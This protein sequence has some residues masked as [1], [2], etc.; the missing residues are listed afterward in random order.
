[1][2][3]KQKLTDMEDEL[4]RFRLYK[5]PSGDVVVNV[6]IEEESVWLTQK[7]M[8][9]LFDTTPQNITIH[10]RNIFESCELEELSTCK[11][12]LQ[13]QKEGGRQYGEFNKT[14][15]IISDFDKQIR[16]LKE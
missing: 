8:G 14:Q 5:A 9:M 6:I 12:I 13:V 1:M 15:K 4:R 16:R 3:Y 11:E 10:L 7:S 2:S